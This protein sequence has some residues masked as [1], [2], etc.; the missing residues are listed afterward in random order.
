MFQLWL[1][2]VTAQGG[3]IA[4]EESPSDAAPERRS[5]TAATMI[6]DKPISQSAHETRNLQPTDPACFTNPAYEIPLQFPNPT[7]EAHSIPPIQIPPHLPADYPTRPFHVPFQVPFHVPFH[8]PSQ[9]PSHGPSHLPSHVPTV[10]QTGPSHVPIPFQT[11]PFHGPPA[12]YQTGYPQ[13]PAAYPTTYSYG[14]VGYQ[15]ANLYGIRSHSNK[16]HYPNRFYQPAVFNGPMAS[17]SHVNARHM[18]PF[19]PYGY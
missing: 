17:T 12:V 8:V 13:V 4:E 19:Q 1:L 15:T 5:N 14:P 3:A 9:I 10:Y 11:G 18:I 16:A 6:G 7:Y 2:V